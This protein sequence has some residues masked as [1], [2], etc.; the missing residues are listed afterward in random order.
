SSE[1]AVAEFA[2]GVATRMPAHMNGDRASILV[3]DDSPA[4]LLTV[5]TVLS[6]LGQMIVTT[7]SGREA[8]RRLLT[9]DFAVI[10]VDV[11]MPEMDGFET[12]SMIRQRKRFEHT[13]IIF[14]SA[15]SRPETHALT[16]YTLGAVDYI[17]TPI[18][19]EILRTKVGVFVDLHLKTLEVERQ[20]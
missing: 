16:G 13:P 10:L 12:A 9:E 3:V 7:R 4:N 2:T 14:M 5:E 6:S 18:Q 15:V 17:F 20:G 19:P 1:R 8:L 11:N